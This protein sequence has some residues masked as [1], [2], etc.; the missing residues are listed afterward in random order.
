MNPLVPAQVGTEAEGFPTVRAF[1]GLFSSMDSLVAQQIQSLRKG[2][3]AL[4]ADVRILPRVTSLGGSGALSL[5]G[6]FVGGSC[7]PFLFSQK[8]ALLLLFQL[9]P[10]LQASFMSGYLRKF[11]S[12]PFW[13]H[14]E[15]ESSSSR[16]HLY[17]HNLFK[18]D[19]NKSPNH[20]NSKQVF[21]SKTMQVI[22][23]L[24][25]FV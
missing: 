4:R 3:P 22:L 11:P 16:S 5:P 7:F 18:D 20:I 1:V 10:T 25:P 2:L 15:T 17:F 24:Q 8:Q 12:G 19:N 21:V 9:P 23:D 14:H 6:P 13:R